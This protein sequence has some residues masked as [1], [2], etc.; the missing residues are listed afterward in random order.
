MVYRVGDIIFVNLSP[1][2]GE[3]CGGHRFAKIIK[4]KG[5]LLQIIPRVMDWSTGE[6]YFDDFQQRTIDTSRIIE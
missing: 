5:N 2:Y 4:I 3:E 1:A 6:F